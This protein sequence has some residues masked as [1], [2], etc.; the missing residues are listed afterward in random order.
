MCH[1]YKI[2]MHERVR[3]WRM[4]IPRLQKRSLN[5]ISL[6]R[7]IYIESEKN[8][9]FVLIFRLFLFSM[10]FASMLE[11]EFDNDKK[12]KETPE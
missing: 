7:S 12:K 10:Q 11:L 8:W 5:D 6:P 4:L 2:D 3:L 1:N 9:R